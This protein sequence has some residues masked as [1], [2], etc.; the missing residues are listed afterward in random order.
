ML[1][2][3]II[4]KFILALVLV[5]AGF[6]GVFAEEKKVVIGDAKLVG[7]DFQVPHDSFADLKF[8]KRIYDNPSRL[9]FDI[10]G[11]NLGNKVVSY[12]LPERFGLKQ[13][14][15]AQFDK[16]TVRVVIEGAT[17]TALEKVRIENVGRVLHFRFGMGNI[18]ISDIAMEQAN[19]RVVAEGAIVPRTILLDNPTRLVVDL[20]GSELKSPILAKSFNIADE[21]IK[22]SQLDD[23]I[24]RIV[25]TGP[26]S[27]LRDVRISTNEKQL[28][29]LQEGA[30]TAPEPQAASTISKLLSFKVTKSSPSETVFSLELK[31]EAK[32]KFLKLHNPERLVVDLVDVNFDE[33]LS[34]E[35]LPETPHVKSTRFGLATLGRPVTR[36][37][38]DLKS[39]DLIEEFKESLD[40]KFLYIR[41]QGSSKDKASG[42]GDLAV[43]LKSQ[44]V[45]VVLDAGHG[46]YDHGAIYGGHNEKDINLQVATRVQENLKAAGIDAYMTRNED[47]FMSLSE[48]VELSNTIEPKIFVSMHANALVTNPDMQGLQTYYHSD[49]GL[50][51]GEYIHKRLVKDVGMLDQR[52]RHANFWVCKYTKAP[53]ILLELGFMTNVEER[54]KLT[55]DS[56]QAE[57]AKA[58]SRGIIEYL[59]DH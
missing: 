43:S 56:Y 1:P 21:S 54:N 14:R 17:V 10:L 26:K 23:S 30:K 9:V 16:D 50:K 53:S 15:L 3:K 39:A 12:D 31:G 34:A 55:R 49:G 42:A 18:K 36:I 47:R 2:N 57:L 8:K 41:L 44:G 29:V 27:N 51:L 4:S 13:V 46:G 40:K 48:R 33:A 37:V 32:Y 52:V 20:I 59:E 11:A 58:I 19:L 6:I 7:T 5:C 38:F 25:F 35:V 22:V 24:V 45:R 28:L